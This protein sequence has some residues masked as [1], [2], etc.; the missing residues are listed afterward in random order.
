MPT[1]KELRANLAIARKRLREAEDEM[2]TERAR[3]R[4]LRAAYS[5]TQTVRPEALP[6]SL[7]RDGWS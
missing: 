6:P 7:R 4:E 5:E 3:E 1:M 2:L